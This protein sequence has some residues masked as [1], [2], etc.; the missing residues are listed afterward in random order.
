MSPVDKKST[1]DTNGIEE[2][3][4]INVPMDKFIDHSQFGNFETN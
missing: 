2:K 3:S 4:N 1:M